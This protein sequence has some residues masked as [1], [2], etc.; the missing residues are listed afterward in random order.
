MLHCTQLTQL[1]QE[2]KA[3]CAEAF[4]RTS[5]R[6][7]RVPSAVSHSVT[8]PKALLATRK[9]DPEVNDVGATQRSSR[10]ASFRQLA[11][12][13][14]TNARQSASEF[15]PKANGTLPS[16]LCYIYGTGR[17][18]YNIYIHAQFC[19]VKSVDDLY[20][21]VDRYALTDTQG[22]D[23]QKFHGCNGRQAQRQ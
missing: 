11:P 7:H 13:T 17:T 21:L 12:S 20:L 16:D 10:F 14:G 15:R 4:I 3:R 19:A 18:S 5:P 6:L 22:F 2:C 8:L 1:E 23:Q 9:I